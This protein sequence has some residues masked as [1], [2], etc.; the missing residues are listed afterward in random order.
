MEPDLAKLTADEALSEQVQT[1]F[2]SMN[3]MHENLMSDPAIGLLS[4]NQSVEL[5]N[6]FR[7]FHPLVRSLHGVILDD[8]GTSDHH[9]FVCSTPLKG[10]V[11]YLAHDGDS[12]IVFEILH[13]FLA[14]AVTAKEMD[15][16]VSEHHPTHALLA[17]EQA[18]LRDHLSALRLNENSEDIIPALIPSL[19]LSEP[20][21]LISLIGD[22]F[23]I[24]EAIARQVAARPKAELL[25]VAEFCARHPHMMVRN[26]GNAARAK[27]LGG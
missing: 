23:F 14:A 17:K 1:Y 25:P 2:S 20:D 24:G 15:A 21:F 27:I 10:M 7:Q 19:D 6:E 18:A 3:E 26:A 13:D 22:D 16:S 9:V 11:L 4:L 12:R 5:S 8:P